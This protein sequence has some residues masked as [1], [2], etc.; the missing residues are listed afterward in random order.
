MTAE[1]WW[2]HSFLNL[3]LPLLF[4]IGAVVAWVLDGRRFAWHRCAREAVGQ[5]I[6]VLAILAGVGMFIQVFTATGGR[7][8]GRA[9]CRERGARGVGGAWVER[10][11]V[12]CGQVA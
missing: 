3:G 2:P 8:I 12:T 7:E 4:F 5:A 11:M 9:S 10:Y 6:P 1:R